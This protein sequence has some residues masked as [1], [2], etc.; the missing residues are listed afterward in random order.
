[1]MTSLSVLKYRRYETT[2]DAEN[3]AFLDNEAGVPEKMVVR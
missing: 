3:Y 2:Y 1:M